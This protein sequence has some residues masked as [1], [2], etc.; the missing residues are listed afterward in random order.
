MR[1]LEQHPDY[2][3]YHSDKYLTKEI[4]K[5]FVEALIGYI[6]GNRTDSTS[7]R[8]IINTIAKHVPCHPGYEWKL[9]YLLA[10]LEKVI[11]KLYNK[12]NFPKFMDCI[13]E[14]T[15]KYFINEVDEINELLM[16]ASIGYK[17]SY[18]FPEGM[19]W[20]V[21]NDIGKQT[22]TLSETLKEIPGTYENTIEHLQQAKEQLKKIDTSRA[23]KDA[24]RD[25]V[26]ALEA[27]LKY[28]S[29]ESKLKNA[30]EYL[31]NNHQA[32]KK[33]IRDALT[34]WDLVNDK[35]PDIRHGTTVNKDLPEEEVLYWIDR[36]MALIK[37][38]SRWRKSNGK[39]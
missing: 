4:P 8:N 33:I 30:V 18:C 31:I 1:F 17:L 10:D 25:C 35:I 32:N 7:L 37:Y 23:R 24:L 28:I 26:S 11:W 19:V 9:P 27:Y 2:E 39:D 5:D 36:I 38:I 15:E 14:L 3:T 29:G 13:A 6:V 20:E 16:E 22:Q 34:I 21:N 12:K